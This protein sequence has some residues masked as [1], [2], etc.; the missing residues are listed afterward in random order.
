MI[1][2]LPS[3]RFVSFFCMLFSFEFQRFHSTM[4]FSNQ[5]NSCQA[6]GIGKLIKDNLLKGILLQNI[7]FREVYFEHL[8]TDDQLF[9]QE[10]LLEFFFFQN[11]AWKLGVRLIHEC[12]R[13]IQE[14]EITHT[15]AG[16]KLTKM[17]NQKTYNKPCAL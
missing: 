11:Y 3:K 6:L 8:Q 15:R 7:R 2:Q 4:G 13:Y 14:I 17:S 9:L 12:L 5:D 16:P 10:C 1:V